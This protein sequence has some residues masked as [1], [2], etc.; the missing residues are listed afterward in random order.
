MHSIVMVK[1]Q[2]VMKWYILQ[3]FQDVINFL[4]HKTG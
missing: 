3:W 2:K 4:L 1:L